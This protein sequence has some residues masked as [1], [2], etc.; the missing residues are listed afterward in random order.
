M[1]TYFRE[2]K[3]AQAQLA[4]E[5]QQRFIDLA[6]ANQVEVAAAALAKRD[7]EDAQRQLE[8][9]HQVNLLTQISKALEVITDG[10]AKQAEENTKAILALASASA[11]QAKAFSGWLSSFQMSAPPT[12]SVVRDEDELEEEEAR[13]MDSMPEEFK[14]AFSLH[15]G[16]EDFIASVKK[17]MQP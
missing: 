17:D 5:E 2:R 3:A 4:R 9:D 16:G 11:E 10:S 14:L 7:H 13:L 6:K 12:S 8:R 15:N 1:F